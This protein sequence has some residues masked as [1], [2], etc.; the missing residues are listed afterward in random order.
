M[1][2]SFIPVFV[3]LNFLNFLGGFFVLDVHLE[4]NVDANI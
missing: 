3:I 2:V 4:G 1:V